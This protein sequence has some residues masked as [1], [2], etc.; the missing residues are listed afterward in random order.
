M[1]PITNTNVANLSTNALMTA[2]W[3][4]AIGTGNTGNI[5]NIHYFASSLKNWLAAPSAGTT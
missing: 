3:K 4:L 1:L 2:D 5:G